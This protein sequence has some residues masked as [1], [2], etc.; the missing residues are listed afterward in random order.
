VGDVD[1]GEEM[2]CVDGLVCQKD[3]MSEFYLLGGL[4]G[5][6]RW[7]CHLGQPFLREIDEGQS[8]CEVV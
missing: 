5:Y 4:I 3:W 1:V 7:V 8:Q 2:G 6:L